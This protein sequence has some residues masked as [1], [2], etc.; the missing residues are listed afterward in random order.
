M[1]YPGRADGRDY[2]LFPRA[3]ETPQPLPGAGK[4]YSKLVGGVAHYFYLADDGT[5]YQMT[6]TVSGGGQTVDFVYDTSTPSAGNSYDN[7]ADLVTA[8]NA[9][10]CLCRVLVKRAIG[11]A[12][13]LAGNYNL[14]NI[15]FVGQFDIN[16]NTPLVLFNGAT[17]NGTFRLY[18]DSV[19]FAN[20]AAGEL[21]DTSNGNCS[22][23]L[24]GR[25]EL[26]GA[27][28]YIAL[29]TSGAAI[30]LYVEDDA[31]LGNDGS[32]CFAASL[33]GTTLEAHVE[34]QIIAWSSVL[35]P[36]VTLNLYDYGG[37]PIGLLENSLWS[38]SRRFHFAPGQTNINFA[39]QQNDFLIP[40]NADI[41]R[42]T[43]TGNQN[44]T[45]IES[46]QGSKV[47]TIIN[48]DA[49]DTLTIVNNSVASIISNRFLTTTGANLAVAPNRIAHAIYDLTSER[50]RSWLV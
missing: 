44:L 2:Y 4:A 37:E 32:E 28:G 12:S 1:G 10:G 46:Q 31:A 38:D 24:K 49:V 22:I 34:R 48:A 26:V 7:L 14:T 25:A 17:L 41:I 47:L 5:E 23:Y 15:E 19:R 43:L 11:D 16:G 39:A 13:L 40:Y 35:T 50:W 20:A 18:L 33:A 6:P 21:I 27:G 29:I 9:L 36:D 45:G 42:V 30:R 3:L 8:A